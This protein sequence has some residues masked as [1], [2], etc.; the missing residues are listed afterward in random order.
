MVTTLAMVAGA[1]GDDDGGPSL[2]DFLPPLP[3][4]DGTAQSVYAG[5]V[6]SPDQLVAGPA[7]SGLVGDYYIRNGK[8]SF[9]I[10]GPARFIGV[11]P[12][13]GNVVDAVPLDAAG[14]PLAD[15]HL[16]EISMVYIL[17][18][19]CAHERV[20]VLLDGAG[21]GPAVIRA[22]GVAKTNDFINLKGI[23]ILNVPSDQDPDIEDEVECA[24]TYTLRP[25]SP[26]LEIQWTLFNPSK[27]NIKG[28]FGTLND[29]GG[30]VE[31][32]SP[33]V[34]G[35][36][37][38]GI[39]SLLTASDP[40]PVPYTVYQGPGVAYGLVPVHQDPTKTA[41]TILVAG[42]SIIIFG[43]DNFLDI[44][45]PDTFYLQL[46]S[47][48]GVT[49][50]ADLVVGRVA[51]D[52][53]AAYRG[54]LGEAMTEV[55]GT[56]AY[57][58]SGAPGAGVR[59]AVFQDPDGDG[60]LDDDEHPVT[61]FDADAEG[62]WR[63]A[64]LPGH[65][66]VRGDVKDVT[67]SGAK[68][69]DVAATA[70]TGV[71][72]AM[73]EP[74][75]LDFTVTDSATGQ[76]IPAKIT[77]IGRHP[78]APDKRV[79]ESYDRNFGVV[80]T[81]HAVY[82]TSVPAAMGD[83]ADQPML[84][85]AGG[86]YRVFA[87]RGP[88][89]T[90]ASTVITPTAGQTGTIDLELTRVVDTA[91][92]VATEFH[93]HAIG[94][95]DSPVPFETR[96]RSLVVEGIEFFAST[97]HD[98]LSDYDPLIDAMGLR[99]LIDGVVGIESTPF[100]YGHFIAYPLQTDAADPSNGAVDWAAGTGGFAMLPG[101]IWG[102]LRT[103]GARVIQI[104]HPRATSGFTG[105][106]SY[107]DVSGLTFDFAGRSIFGSAND[108][109][110]PAEWLR[111]SDATKVFSDDFESLETWNGFKTEDT[112]GD[113]VRETVSLDLVMRDWFNFLGF[114]KVVTPIGNSD[115]HTREKDPAGL[116]RTMVRVADDSAAGL[117]LGVDEDVYATVLGDGAPR[118]VVVTNGPMLAVEV[119]G[120]PAI[121]RVLT[122][123]GAGEVTL[124]VTA[125][126]PEW[127]DFDTIEIF[128]NAS[129][130]EKEPSS[131]ALQ[132]ILCYTSRDPGSIGDLDVCK[133]ATGGTQPLNVQLQNV[134]GQDRRRT[135]T[136]TF[137][138]AAADVPKRTGAMGDDAWVVVRVRGQRAMYPVL[139]GFGEISGDNIDTLVSGSE[140]EVAAALT[141]VGT[142]ATAFS[143]AIFVDF[144]GG[145]WRAPFAP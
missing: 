56:V 62:T 25:D 119:G 23:G 136:I 104:N 68:V 86:P 75:K 18:R 72:I 64:L 81:F 15:D 125:T 118:D 40:A 32:F 27:H 83:P 92:Y 101:E 79:Q 109:P 87:S 84:L 107:F 53:E 54:R 142:P 37:R 88:E 33:G 3:T 73:P 70:V 143:G 113:G 78:A 21:G 26:T 122:P 76:A 31:A 2:D 65:Y 35:F 89:W 47:G 55:S 126:A 95:P 6:S 67:R 116:P 16:G 141:N 71:D 28:P 13:G 57:M 103:R 43:A 48:S 30:D 5:Q 46:P 97:D 139:L 38:V 59:V 99:G 138:L 93:Q 140:A 58:P 102:A 42:V 132:P 9:V 74:A 41:A 45:N 14:Q 1:C 80:R 17:G 100:A 19:T 52:I 60:I 82:G 110:V 94:S 114:G 29:T 50:A 77:V 22:R 137:S 121:G 117:M 105:F 39:D 123:D 145:G 20:D 91:G 69:L 133:A 8:A 34:V 85:P 134:S 90:V 96:L 7:K 24:T 10:Q 112:N 111:L 63:G 130:D 131:T 66:L 108:Q 127:V 36:N 11:I 124:T 135:A 4:P 144:D 61:Y 98:Y 129:Y 12:W 120:Q 51:G 115:T 44:V 128:A 49:H 106:Q